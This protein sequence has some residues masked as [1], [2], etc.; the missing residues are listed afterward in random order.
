MAIKEF[1]FYHGAVLTRILRKDIPLTLTLI[2]TNTLE[3]WSAYKISDNAKDAILYIK[4]C[5]A[6]NVTKNTLDGNT[7]LIKN[8]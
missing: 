1:E 4:Y 3:S 2:E 6:P 8:I 7:Y 5:S